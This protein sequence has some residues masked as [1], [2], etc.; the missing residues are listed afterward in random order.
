M[1]TEVNVMGDFM[2]YR[3]VQHCCNGGVTFRL[4]FGL[5]LS[6][7]VPRRVCAKFLNCQ[8]IRQAHRA[9]PG[10]QGGGVGDTSCL[11]CERGGSFNR[12]RTVSNRDNGVYTS[13]GP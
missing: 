9:I 6:L 8:M 4:D 5:D 12:T 7:Q 13:E 3:H 1:C 10:K 2:S 11:I